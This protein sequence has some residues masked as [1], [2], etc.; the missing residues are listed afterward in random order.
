M[1]LVIDSTYVDRNALF[2]DRIVLLNR[3][4]IRLSGAPCPSVPQMEKETGDGKGESGFRFPLPASARQVG[5]GEHCY[6]TCCT[7]TP[8][9]LSFSFFHNALCNRVR[10]EVESFSCYHRYGYYTL[11]QAC[12]HQ[13]PLYNA[14]FLLYIDVFSCQATELHTLNRAKLIYKI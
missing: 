11:H 4:P 2:Y 9:S 7:Y 13:P 8:P 12:V 3:I 14:L 1:N 6:K 10:G 5:T